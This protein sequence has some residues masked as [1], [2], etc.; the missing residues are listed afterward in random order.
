[1][2]KMLLYLMIGYVVFR[3]VQLWLRMAASRR[4]RKDFD[5][6]VDAHPPTPPLQNFKNIEDAD[7]ED[8]GQKDQKE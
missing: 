2:F 4:Q 5:P 8:L 1:V 7:F 6:F 3:I